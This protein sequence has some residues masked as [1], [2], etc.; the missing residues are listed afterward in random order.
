MK[1]QLVSAG[2]DA[3]VAK[4]KQ[5]KKYF[6]FWLFFGLSPNLDYSVVLVKDCPTS[7]MTL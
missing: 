5:T 4:S 7:E 6:T 1:N 2:L 3:A